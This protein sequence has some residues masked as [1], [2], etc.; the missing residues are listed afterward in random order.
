MKI[1]LG[2]SLWE[3]SGHQVMS[4]CVLFSSWSELRLSAQIIPKFHPK[5]FGLVNLLFQTKL[6]SSL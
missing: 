6:R 3:I 4:Q 5:S 1:L 2:S